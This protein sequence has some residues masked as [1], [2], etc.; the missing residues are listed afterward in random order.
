M[1]R[2]IHE[3]VIIIINICAP[4]DT[5]LNYIKQNLTDLKEN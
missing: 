5:V 2:S 1:R 4:H 3:E